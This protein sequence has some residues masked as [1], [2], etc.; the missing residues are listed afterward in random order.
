MNNIFLYILLL[1]LFSNCSFNS[2]SSFWTKEKKII[3]HAKHTKIY[4][5]SEQ[6]EHSI[7]EFNKDIKIKFN[8]KLFKN[9]FINKL[10]NNNGIINYDG[11]LQ[12]VSKYKFSRIKNFNKL[13][14]DLIFHNNGLVFFDNKGTILN[15][16]SNSK[17]IWKKNIY[18]KKERKLNPILFFASDKNVLIVTDSISNYYAL[19]IVDGELIWKKNHTSPFNSQIKIYKNNFFTIDYE[20]KLNCISIEDGKKL[21][22]VKT[23]DSF[24]KSIKK[25]S[26]IIKN[27]LVIFN[28]SIGDISAVNIDTGDIVWQT[29]TQSSAIYAEAFKLEISDVIS[30]SNSIY[31]SNNKNEFYSLSLE[32]GLVNWKQKVS[33]SIR[34]TV[35]GKLVFTISSDGFLYVI[36]KNSGNIIR[37]TDVFSDLKEKERKNMKPIGFIVGKKNIYLTNNKGKLF[38]IDIENGKTKK[39]LK[40]DNGKISR[41]LF[42]NDSLYIAKDDSIIKLK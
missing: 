15:F 21:W 34:P 10:D 16:D 40:I 38:L 25:L 41:P 6:E 37:I 42:L 8:A 19:N 5:F 30:E 23:E 33:S 24:V 31:F 39:I 3:E 22:N 27:N 32:S 29:P 7:N 35:V 18:T 36:E 11:N 9:S 1:L 17:L 14:P 26:L 2:K 4:K 12:K 20:S 28:N 13:E